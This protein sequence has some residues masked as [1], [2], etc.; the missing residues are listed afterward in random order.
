MKIGLVS[1]GCPKNLV[2][3]EVMLGLAQQAGHESRRP[4]RGRRAGVNTCAFIDGA[5][6][7]SV[8][9]ILEMAAGTRTTAAAAGWSSPAAWPSAIATSC[10]RRSRRSTRCS[11]P[12]RCPRIVDAIEG[13]PAAPAAGAAPVTLFAR[14]PPAGARRAKGVA[15]RHRDAVADARAAHLHL[16]RV[17]AARAD[18]AAALRLREGR[19]G[20]RLQLRL[21]HHPDA[22]RPLP[23]P[24]GRRHRREAR[25]LAARGVKELLLI[26]QD[27]TFYGIDRQRARRAR[28][29]AA[30]RSTAVDGLEWIRLLYLYPTTITDEVLD[31]MAR[32]RQGVQVHRPAAAARAR[33]GAEAD[34]AARQRRSL[35]APAG[36]DP[37]PRARR[38]PSHRRSS[39]GSRARP[40][41]SSRTCALRAR[42]RVRP[43]RGL[44]LLAR[45][46]HRGLR[47]GRRRAAGARSAAPATPDGLQKRIVA[48]RHR[49]THRRA[50]CRVLVDGPSPE[51]ELVLQG[52]LEGQAPDIDSGRA[53]SPMRP[54]RTAAAPRRS[55]GRRLRLVGGP[56]VRA[57]A[58][59][60]AVRRPCGQLWYPIGCCR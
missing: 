56:R 6:Q 4:G 27:T 16:R 38:L 21:L 25:Q 44:H 5:K 28:A 8:D 10:S 30:T 58:L 19:R 26:S 41:R 57:G 22:A 50:T 37:R 29:A 9:A 60:P 18:H 42:R 35:R 53:T 11:A 51:H 43:R 2:D 36:A 47:P 15:A 54:A 14:Q 33:L 24:A 31:A 46:R 40:R 45:G 20:L 12:A 1:L 3:S 48:R 49:R 13:T 32:V 7:E 59:V 23:Q 52:R 55:G 34:A 17:D 39:S